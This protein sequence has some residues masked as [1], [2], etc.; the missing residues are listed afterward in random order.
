[1]SQRSCTKRRRTNAIVAKY[2]MLIP[3]K[4]EWD[5]AGFRTTLF[6]HCMPGVLPEHVDF[7]GI[8]FCPYRNRTRMRE[9]RRAIRLMPAD[10]RCNDDE[11]VTGRYTTACTHVVRL[12]RQPKLRGYTRMSGAAGYVHHPTCLCCPR[13]H[14]I[15]PVP[16][17]LAVTEPARQPAN[18]IL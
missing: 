12:F 6:V 5:N 10:L 1:M 16:W 3:E 17:S 15:C 4:S 7:Y 14:E 18:Q 8:W 11:D 2:E 13:S 9:G